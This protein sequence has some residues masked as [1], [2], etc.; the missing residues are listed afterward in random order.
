MSQT[1]GGCADWWVEVIWLLACRPA[2]PPPTPPNLVVFSVDTLRADRMGAWGH[3]RDTTPFLSELAATSVRYDGA[4]SPSSWTLPSMASML[5]GSM[6]HQHGVT[7]SEHALSPDLETLAERL[8]ELGYDTAFFGVNA[9]FTLDHGLEQGFDVWQGSTGDSGRVLN[10]RVRAYLDQRTS[11]APLF[12][13]VHWYEPHCRYRPPRDVAD[14]FLPATG[15]SLD[16]A[17]YER[18]GDCFKLQRDDGTPELDLGVYL[19]RY[20]AEIV[21]VDARMGDLWADLAPL[22]PWLGV[23]ADHGEAF[24]EHGDFG[25][26]RQL[27]QESVR[28]P[29]LIRPVGGGAP[30]V[31]EE[32]VSALVLSDAV[33]EQVG[34][35]ALPRDFVGSET[36]DEGVGLRSV[37]DGFVK[38]I[39]GP[40]GRQT[41][42]LERDPDE[43]RPMPGHLGV[44]A[45]PTGTAPVLR[46]PADAERQMLREL[47]YTR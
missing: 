40:T 18:M 17:D 2:V 32:P 28:V 8:G 15:R 11:T 6:P 21:E 34:L 5:V 10:D 27:F 16:P 4:V 47:G 43:R 20:D 14:R 44:P 39:S 12:L 31:V 29:L 45:L 26:G 36:D 3:E 37:Y 24:W 42:D 25:H 46:E 22:N 23:V 30:L 1:P 9:T 35:T 13:W 33:L 19:A 41:F 7:R 38:T